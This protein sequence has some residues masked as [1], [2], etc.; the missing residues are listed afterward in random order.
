ML[1]TVGR[2]I[3]G[4]MAAL[5]LDENFLMQ[6]GSIRVECSAVLV[7]D[8]I[9]AHARV[10]S[11]GTPG[12]KPDGMILNGDGIPATIAMAV[13]FQTHTSSTAVVLCYC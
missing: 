11:T 5:A 6:D 2:L 7:G 9:V 3:P 1:R 8:G 13:L 10:V 4:D 12:L